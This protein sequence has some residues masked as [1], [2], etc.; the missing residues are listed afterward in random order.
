MDTLT[1]LTTRRSVK[2]FED[3]PVP[4]ELVDTIIDAGLHAP[5]G[6]RKSVV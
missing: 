4:A 6:D 3:K 1:A 2:K 5:S